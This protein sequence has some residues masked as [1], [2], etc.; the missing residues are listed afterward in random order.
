[1][2][3]LYTTSV[4]A[5]IQVV[6]ISGQVSPHFLNGSGCDSQIKGRCHAGGFETLETPWVRLTNTLR[7]MKMGEAGARRGERHPPGLAVRARGRPSP[8]A[9]GAA[10]D[11]QKAGARQHTRKNLM[12]QFEPAVLVYIERNVLVQATGTL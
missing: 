1:M 12:V 6:N 2:L 4:P 8:A 10:R 9:R 11:Q 3:L 7:R 5:N